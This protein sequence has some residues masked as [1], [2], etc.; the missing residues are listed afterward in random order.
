M[1]FYRSLRSSEKLI[2]AVTFAL[3]L[4][5]PFLLSFNPY[6]LSIFVS[7]LILGSVSLA[8]NFLAGGC[9]QV[10][11]GH[12][13]FFGIGAYAS[14]LLV[15][16]SGWNPFLAMIAAAVIGV[17]GALIIGIPAFRLRGPYFALSILGFA[18]V[19][20]LL[21][22]NLTD[23]TEGSK[24]IYNISSLPSVNLGGMTFE[25]YISRTTN[26][27]FGALLMF[28]IYL[29]IYFFRR[30]NT[31]LAMSAVRGDEETAAG[32]GVPVFRTKVTALIV[33]A[34][35]TALMGAFYAHY[36]RFLN[37]DSA[38]DGYWSV[39]PIVGSLFGGIGTL[40]GPSIGAL[41][42]TALDEFVF[43]RF[44]ETGHKLFFGLLLATVIVWTPVGLLGKWMKKK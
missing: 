25:F 35:C 34:F 20:K 26:Y 13:A 23:L 38:F 33:S 8:W 3:V 39:M 12:A 41:V 1:K 28:A 5:L 9:G 40:I 29:V 31:G 18:E 4:C 7:A 37:P 19:M 11:F 44:F 42:I 14:A 22:L 15:M 10:S 32:I 21:T 6:Y 2:A 36:I 30:S 24:G 16:K 17:L 43:K 27:Y